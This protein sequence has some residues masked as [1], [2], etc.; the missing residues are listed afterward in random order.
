MNRSTEITVVVP[1]ETP[2]R[3][4]PVI[5][6]TCCKNKSFSVMLLNLFAM[7]SG[8]AM[9]PTRRSETARLEI[10]IIEG[11][12]MEGV[13][14]MAANTNEF[15]MIEMRIRGVLITEL[16]TAMFFWVAVSLSS[17]FS[18][19]LCSSWKL[20]SP[21]L[22]PQYCI[23]LL[24]NGEGRKWSS[25]ELI[26]R[27][28]LSWFL[29]AAAPTCAFFFSEKGI[30]RSDVLVLKSC[31]STQCFVSNIFTAPRKFKIFDFDFYAPC[32]LTWGSR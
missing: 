12:R 15:P 9:T 22:F 28:K 19:S 10:M 5:T 16:M 24:V 2:Q 20:R 14:K 23:P 13:F 17:I 26:T 21:L 18:P 32:S 7:K 4:K 1:R 27:A 3:K 30:S 11:V 25:L 29:K 31:Y 6:V 8:W